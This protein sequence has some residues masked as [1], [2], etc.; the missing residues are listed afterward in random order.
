ML[1]LNAP[2]FLDIP[3]PDPCGCLQGAKCIFTIHNLSY[4]ADLVGRAMGACD[5]ATTVSPT[6]AQEVRGLSCFTS[7]PAG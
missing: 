4:G 3:L 2:L 6:Y 5:I 1:P 7:C